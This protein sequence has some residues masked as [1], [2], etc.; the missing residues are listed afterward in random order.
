MLIIG[1]AGG[2]G[3]GK[4]TVV[5]AN[6]ESLNKKV[7]I[8][9]QDSYYKDS[10]H[11]PVEDRKQINFDHPDAIDWDL[12]CQQ[13]SELKAGYKSDIEEDAREI[14]VDYQKPVK[15]ESKEYS[16]PSVLSWTLDGRKASHLP[17]PAYRCYGAGVVCVAIAVDQQGKVINAK[18]N[19]AA[20]SDDS[21][22]RN[23]AIRAARMSRF[24]RDLNAPVRQAGEI[25]YSYI[26]Q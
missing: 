15:E 9:S 14:A 13:I 26:A 17:I 12:L 1:I 6:T 20:S 23:F 7:A 21:C 4:T 8:I 5:K 24:N 11:I 25:V 10:S 16:G 2:S 3:S 18:V 22:L 19:D